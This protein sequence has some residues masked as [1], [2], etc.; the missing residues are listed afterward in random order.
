MY[1]ALKQVEAERSRQLRA[2]ADE[3][4]AAESHPW[5]RLPEAPPLAS[6]RLLRERTDAIVARVEALEKLAGERLQEIERNLQQHVERRLDSLARE[7]N[8]SRTTI[9]NQMRQQAELLNRRLSFVLGGIGL[10]AIFVLL[11]G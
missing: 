8:A 2:A 1:D 11:R 5:R 10:L 7:A 3:E 4:R 6:E 9:A